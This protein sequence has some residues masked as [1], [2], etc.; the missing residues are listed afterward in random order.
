MRPL[1]RDVLIGILSVIACIEIVGINMTIHSINTI[2]T[3]VSRV[4]TEYSSVQKN[5]DEYKVIHQMGGAS[6]GGRKGPLDL[7]YIAEIA[8]KAG[9]TKTPQFRDWENK[10]RKNDFKERISEMKVYA[11]KA[12]PM[13]AF[14]ESI[15]SL[16]PM[17]RIKSITITRTRGK[18]NLFDVVIRHSEYSV[19]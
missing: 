12:K 8:S 2:R 5:L 4:R 9:I 13:Y 1:L 3:E 15:D 17:N 18:S 7:S 6:S 14:L 19:P 16:G 10:G 11:A